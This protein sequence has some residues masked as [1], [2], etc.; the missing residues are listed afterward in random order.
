MPKQETFDFTVNGVGDREAIIAS[1]TCREITI[2]EKPTVALWP[3]TD[4]NVSNV[5]SG[6]NYTH[7]KLGTNY[8]F[9]SPSSFYAGEIVGYVET[10]L[11]DGTPSGSSTFERIE[12]R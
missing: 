2:R 10:A 12:E 4:Y 9:R 11:A 3:T 6:G 5:A 7:R 8:T 1:Q